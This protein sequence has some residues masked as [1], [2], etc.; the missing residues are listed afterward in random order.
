MPVT[1]GELIDR[2]FT[3]DE[4][5]FMAQEI[6]YKIRRM[7][8]D[9]F[10]ILYGTEDGLKNLFDIFKK[11]CDLNYQRNCLIDEIDE[12]IVEIVKAGI[13]GQEIEKYISRKHKTY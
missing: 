5:M 6:L 3:V 12:K 8:F 13:S 9:E 11:S 10:K 7:E 4:K 1:M 2:L